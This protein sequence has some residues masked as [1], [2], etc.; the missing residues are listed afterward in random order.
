MIIVELLD[1]NTDQITTLLENYQ[2][3]THISKSGIMTIE[4]NTNN[5]NLNHLISE[6]HSTLSNINDIKIE[7][8]DIEY[9]LNKVY[10]GGLNV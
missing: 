9:V 8:P 2:L 4:V 7:L 6:L 5:H 10:S 1:E 3:A